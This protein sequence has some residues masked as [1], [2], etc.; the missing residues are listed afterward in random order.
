VLVTVATTTNGSSATA[1]G[2]GDAFLAA[3]ALAVFGSLAA[4]IVLPSAC[5]FLPKLQL[6]PQVDAHPL[7]MP[8]STRRTASQRARGRRADAERSVAAIFD[9]AVDALASEPEVSMAEIARRAGVVRA[10][11]YVRFPIRE[12]LIEAVTERSIGE[13]VEMIAVAEPERGDPAEALQRALIAA[14][15]FVE[16]YHALV[17][18]NRQLLQAELRR[19]HRPVLALLQP[20][21]NRADKTAR[22]RRKPVNSI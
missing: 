3:G 13:A 10:T 1:G 5:S 20:C 7:T 8:R 16:R 14:W 2:I 22:V 21:E 4:L 9:A 17:A 11:I 12:V 15:R 19:R 18:L 6:A